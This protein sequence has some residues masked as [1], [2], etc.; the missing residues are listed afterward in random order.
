MKQVT[1][2]VLG[3][4]YKLILIGLSCDETIHVYGDNHSASSNTSAPTYQLKNKSNSIAYHFLCEGVARDEWL[5]T[6]VN[7]HN[8]TSGLVAR[9]FP[10]GEKL[11][12]SLHRLL[13]WLHAES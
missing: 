12:K 13:I 9:Y 3:L 2:Y 4:R 6:Y 10:S 11:W 1:E 5:T 8:N 7:M